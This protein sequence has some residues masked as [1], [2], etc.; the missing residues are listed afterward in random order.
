VCVVCACANIISVCDDVRV[1]VCILV[2][3]VYV[4]FPCLRVFSCMY[5]YVYVSV[6]IYICV[7]VSICGFQ[8][9]KRSFGSCNHWGR[10]RRCNLL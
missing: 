1:C 2:N 3:N 4:M 5:V 9:C 6:Y 7:C 10:V 8:I